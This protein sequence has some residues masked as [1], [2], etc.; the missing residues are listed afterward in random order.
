MHQD[1][2]RWGE[3]PKNQAWDK[4]QLPRAEDNPGPAPG[5]RRQAVLRA[6]SPIFPNPLTRA[7]VNFKKKEAE[8]GLMGLSKVCKVSSRWFETQ[9]LFYSN[10]YS[11]C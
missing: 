6:P 1:S 2:S 11:P 9:D 10:A 3:L 4:P 8:R 7:L 5:Q